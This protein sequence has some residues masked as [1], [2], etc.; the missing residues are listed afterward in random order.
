MACISEKNKKQIKIIKDLKVICDQNSIKFWMLGGWGID[1]LLGRITRE[2]DD[3]DLIISY[4]NRRL[5]RDVIKPY[6]EKIIE[7]STVRLWF[8]KDGIKCDI[9][10]FKKLK[11][12]GLIMDLDKSDPLVYPVPPD[13]F[14]NG[15]NGR[16]PGVRVRVVSWSFNYTAKEG[17]HYYIDTPLRGKDKKDL[18]LIYENLSAAR[19]KELE[20]YLPGMKREEI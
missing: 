6:A 16:L 13:S 5:C 2:H 20:K 1:V 18:E 10:F 8:F 3:I 17:Y 11:N 15:I 9:R 14:P 7:D 12:G 19:R 4:S